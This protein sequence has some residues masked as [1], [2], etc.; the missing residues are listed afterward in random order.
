MK[1][2]FLFFFITKHIPNRIT[3]KQIATTNTRPW[4]KAAPAYGGG[5]GGGPINREPIR[6]L[7]AASLHAASLHAAQLTEDMLTENAR[8]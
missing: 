4:T 5:I 6:G 7:H 3:S 1:Q 8:R 2:F